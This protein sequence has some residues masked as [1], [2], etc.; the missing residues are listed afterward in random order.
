MPFSAH[1]VAIVATL[2]LA[3]SPATSPL[4]AVPDPS[5]LGGVQGEARA[6][7]EAGL[8]SRSALIARTA[9]VVPVLSVL[10]PQIV[11]AAKPAGDLRL[12]MENFPDMRLPIGTLGRLSAD[13]SRPGYLMLWTADET[14]AV[15]PIADGI[16]AGR[17]IVQV[18]PGRV[19][20]LPSDLG[21]EIAICPPA[22]KALW[23]ALHS[24]TPIPEPARQRLAQEMAGARIAEA[25]GAA[26]FRAVVERVVAATPGWA[27]RSY[28]LIYEVLP[29]GPADRHCQ[30][31][32]AVPS[33]PP[34]PTPPPTP[35]RPALPGLAPSSQPVGVRLYRI[36]AG[37]L[38][39][40]T[41]FRPR[42]DLIVVEVRA[43]AACPGLTVLAL[44]AG[45]AVDVLLPNARPRSSPPAASETVRV[46]AIGSGIQLRVRVPPAPGALE[47]VAALCDTHAQR[48]LFQRRDTDGPTT[49]LQPQD[50]EFTALLRDIE[51][52]QRAG[53]LLVG[54]A[55]YTNLGAR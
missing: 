38:V 40:A 16:I 41:D 3:T 46:P 10:Q 7:D 35:P 36:T 48:P 55:G 43:P 53:G 13:A 49:T 33:P 28:T 17:A 18:G 12:W 30:V 23:F 22:G 4:A 52:A 34:A 1:R 15:F 44:G 14:G 32:D 6:D 5:A 8:A 26:R 20:T 51:A 2:L 47:R 37:A 27:A 24:D 42:E 29:G 25:D 9:Q 11:S 19:A 39:E 45:G 21:F 50:P 54:V 31:A